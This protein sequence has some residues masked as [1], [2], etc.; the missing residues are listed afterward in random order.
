[1]PKHRKYQ[2]SSIYGHT[3]YIYMFLQGL[4]EN[5]VTYCPLSTEGED[6]LM[7]LCLGRL[8]VKPVDTRYKSPMKLLI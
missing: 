8:D 2:T 3:E 1:M 7:G 4:D 6:V 5:A